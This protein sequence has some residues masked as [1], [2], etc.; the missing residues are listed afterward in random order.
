MARLVAV[1]LVLAAAGLGMEVWQQIELYWLISPAD[2]EQF[3]HIIQR[4][5]GI[6]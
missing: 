2:P 1:L 6:S 5:S 3:I 4:Q